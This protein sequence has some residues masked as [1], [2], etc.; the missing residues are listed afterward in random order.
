M[1]LTLLS[2]QGTPPPPVIV[3]QTK[4]SGGNADARWL[5]ILLQEL[6]TYKDKSSIRVAEIELCSDV[7]VVKPVVKKVAPK[8]KPNVEDQI[9]LKITLKSKIMEDFDSID[10]DENLKE[11][12]LEEFEEEDDDD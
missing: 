7:K 3:V 1:F 8:K 9:A 6:R 2:N 5:K 11:A 12:L 10:Y 4:K